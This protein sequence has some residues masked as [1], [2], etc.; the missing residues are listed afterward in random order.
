M[1]LIE[2]IDVSKDYLNI[3]YNITIKKNDKLLLTGCNGIGKT[4]FVK[5]LVNYIKHDSGT[6]VKDELKISYLEELIYLPKYL[7]ANEYIKSIE[8]I[9][10]SYRCNKLMGIFKIPLNRKIHE[11]S[12]GN[13]QKLAI[14]ARF[15][16]SYDLIVLDEP[17][18]GLDINTKKLF[19][20]YLE[21]SNNQT[22]LIVTHY[23][24][25]YGSSFIELQL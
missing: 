7:T 22:L 6:I 15:I 18:N 8:D 20:D 21:D 24:N 4:T 19:L 16:G 23:P 10:G 17:L 25:I 12:K 2:F 1:T 3:N 13:K 9:T 14:V 5:I 11:L